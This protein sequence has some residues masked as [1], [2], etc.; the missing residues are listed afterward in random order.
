MTDTSHFN[1]DP[2][3]EDG[4]DIIVRDQP[5]IAIYTNRR[6]DVVI[7]QEGHYPEEDRFVYVLPDNVLKIA[8]K[9]LDVAGIDVSVAEPQPHTE[10]LPVSPPKDATAPGRMRRYCIRKHDANRDTLTEEPELKLLAAE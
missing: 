5:G 10:L 1:W 8:Q 4:E 9:L 3:G 6:G 2:D 7:R